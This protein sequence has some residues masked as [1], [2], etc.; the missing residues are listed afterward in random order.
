[1][2]ASLDDLVIALCV[3]IDELLGPDPRRGRSWP[4]A[5]AVGRRAG[6]PGRRPGA[7]GLHDE[8]RWLRVCYGRLG[9][10]FPICPDQPGYN[11]R[12]RPLAGCW[13]GTSHPWPA[14]PLRGG[15]LRLLDATPVPCAASRETVKRSA[16][17]G[18]ADYG[19]CPSHSRYY[20]GLKLYLL[21]APDGSPIAWCLANPKLGEREV[22]L[23]SA[24]RGDMVA[25]PGAGAHRQGPGRAEVDPSGRPGPRCCCAPTAATSP[26]A[27]AVRPAYGNGSSRSTTPSRASSG[28]RSTPADPRRG[29]PRVAQRL[30]ALAAAIWHNWATR[31]PRSAP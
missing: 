10:L 16:L 7:A 29:S 4:P 14:N 19:W 20:W 1:M 30:L 22:C 12:P 26:P 28:W 17:R 2:H 23:G 21:T 6:L 31:R 9:H 5:A 15:P 18:W 27:T 25:Q 3:T 24:D 8:H 13:T 11:K